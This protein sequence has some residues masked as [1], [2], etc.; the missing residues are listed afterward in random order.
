MV[1]TLKLS[2]YAGQWVG[3]D[4]AGAVQVSAESLAYLL[5]TIDRNSLTGL[6]ILRAPHPEN[7]LVYGLG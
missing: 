7:G 1:R 3:I 2:A 4:P 6:E 5:E